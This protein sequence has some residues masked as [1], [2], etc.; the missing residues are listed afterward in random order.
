MKP[1]IPEEQNYTRFERF[2]REKN[3]KDVAAIRNKLDS[4]QA[5][6]V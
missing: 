5:T 4:G 2:L 1:G 3:G 6:L